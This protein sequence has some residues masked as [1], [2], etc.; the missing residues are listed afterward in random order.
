MKIIHFINN[1]INLVYP[2]VCGICDKLCDDDI[3]KK[4]EIKLKEIA[5]M[6]IDKYNDRNFRKHLYIFKYEG[7]IKQRLIKYKFNEKVYIYK[8]FVNFA[9]KNKKFCDFFKKYDIM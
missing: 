9:L 2:N 1:V 5:K 6:K 4:C 8:A 7:I 3:C